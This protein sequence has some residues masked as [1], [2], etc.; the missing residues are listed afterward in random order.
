MGDSDASAGRAETTR[1]G[2][3]VEGHGR[4][5]VLQLVPSLDQ[6][7]VERGTIEIARALTE[8]GGT[9]L[10]ASRGGRME[11]ALER[12]GGRLI[13]LDVGAKVPWAIRRNA[14]RL[15]EIV[16]AEGVEI[17]HARSRAPAWAGWYAA[18][19]TGVA[20][21]TTW[22]GVYRE[23]LP[24]KRL[25]NGIMA[26]GRPV[27]AVSEFVAEMIRARHPRAEVVVIPRGADLAQFDETVVS[28]A[29]TAALAER[30][31]LV[32]DPRPVVMLPGRLTRWKGQEHFVEAAARLRER[33]GRED[34]VFLMVGGDPEGAFGRALSARIREL[35]LE[36]CVA[37]GGA[38]DDMPAALKLAAVVVSASTEPEAFGR[39]AVEGMAMGRPVV[40]SDH[41]GARETVAEGATGWRY[42]PGDA[43]ALAEAVNRALEMDASGRAHMGAAGRARVAQR[44]TVAR[45]QAE[46]LAVYARVQ[47]TR[48]SQV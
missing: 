1:P 32:E 26:R 16:R 14:R 43:G 39:V 44:F 46:T 48:P 35:G 30:W 9:A 7:G 22:H 23:D 17:L 6:G 33:R 37:L 15:A 25:W 3:P 31:G 40:A 27:I 41:G 21:V 8:A 38:C 11:G 45:M 20:L 24:F 18:R 28:P 29:R 19:A 34:F 2:P 47:N 36:G 4:P 42:P 10:V 12:A 13:R 5:V